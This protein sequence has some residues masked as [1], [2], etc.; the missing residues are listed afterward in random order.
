MTS[1]NTLG[2]RNAALIRRSRDRFPALVTILFS[3]VVVVVVVVVVIAVIIVIVI[4][5]N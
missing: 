3:I 5:T 4:T 1:D 2:G